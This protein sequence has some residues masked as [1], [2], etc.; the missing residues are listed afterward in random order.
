M[1][2]ASLILLSRVESKRGVNCCQPGVN[3]HRPTTPTTAAAPAAS[4]DEPVVVLVG[5][6]QVAVESNV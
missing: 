5:G 3:L 1:K 4:R 6:A 2:E